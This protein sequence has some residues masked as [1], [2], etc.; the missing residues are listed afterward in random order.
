MK[1]W[2]IRVNALQD[3]AW[4][5]VYCGVIKLGARK[6]IGLCDHFDTLPTLCFNNGI[7]VNMREWR[8]YGLRF[9]DDNSFILNLREKALTEI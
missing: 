5:T 9:I 3:G 2:N 6:R 1:N 8:K 7:I 4:K